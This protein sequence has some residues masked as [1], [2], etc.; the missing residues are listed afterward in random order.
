MNSLSEL[1][2]RTKRPAGDPSRQTA[3]CSW[4]QVQP[5]GGGG[6]SVLPAAGSSGAPIGGARLTNPGAVFGAP[7]QAPA[8]NPASLPAVP[9]VPAVPLVP[10]GPASTPAVPLAPFV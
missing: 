5:A 1:V 9:P 6:V 8:S 4:Y 10:S 3:P 2:K 7:L